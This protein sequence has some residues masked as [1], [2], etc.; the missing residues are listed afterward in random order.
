MPGNFMT[1]RQQKENDSATLLVDGVRKI[2][3][4]KFKLNPCNGQISL[5]TGWKKF[6]DEN[7]LKL[8]DVCVF[9]QMESEGVSFKVA[10]FRAREESTP[11]RFQGNF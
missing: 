9:E 11:P 4:V 1:A 3:D 8:D 5:S 7:H 10:I 6:V 2:W